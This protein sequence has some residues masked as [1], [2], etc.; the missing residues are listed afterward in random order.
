MEM[1]SQSANETPS[2]RV[3]ALWFALG[4]YLL[5]MTG[6]TIYSEKISV[7]VFVVEGLINGAL[8][9]VALVASVAWI[10]ERM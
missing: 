5:I 10:R 7:L 6:T 1:I 8:S 3:R 2:R 9:I 4:L